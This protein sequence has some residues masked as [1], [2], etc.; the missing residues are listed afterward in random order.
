LFTAGIRRRVSRNTLNAFKHWRP[1]HPVRANLG[2]PNIERG[3]AARVLGEQA[4]QVTW[5]AGERLLVLDAN[6][7]KS[8]VKAPPPL[9]I[10]F[11]RCGDTEAT[12]G[13]WSVRW[14]IEPA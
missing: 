12:L 8:G 1:S 7:S 14:G 5:R 9:G 10:I 4:V 2:P 3:R 13:P 11:W 6:L